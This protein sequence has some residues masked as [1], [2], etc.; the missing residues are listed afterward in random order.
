M[1]ILLGLGLSV[2]LVGCGS[3]ES[4]V[5]TESAA[6]AERERRQAAEERETVFDPMISTMDRAKGVEDIN[7]NRKAEMDAALEEQE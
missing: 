4:S 1:K 3:P 7:M 6:T 2:L 5:A